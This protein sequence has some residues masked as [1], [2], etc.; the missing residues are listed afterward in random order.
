MPKKIKKIKKKHFVER[1]GQTE[2][3][4]MSEIIAEFAAPLLREAIDE[5]SEEL[6]ILM[7]VASWNLSLMPIEE[8]ESIIKEIVNISPTEKD[9]EIA[10]SI[11]RMLIWRKELFFSHVRRYVVSYDLR[12]TDNKLI[13]NVISIDFD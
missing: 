13:L 1:K 5:K 6:A 11:V 4:N 7:A 9:K 12:W 10:E 2:R 3:I 8:R